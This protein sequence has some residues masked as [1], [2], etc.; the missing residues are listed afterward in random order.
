MPREADPPSSARNVLG[1]P[2]ACCCERP[3]TGFYRDGYLQAH[4]A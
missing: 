4:G 3:R 1:G 2:L